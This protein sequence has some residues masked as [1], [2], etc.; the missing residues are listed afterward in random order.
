MKLKFSIAQKLIVGFGV[1]LFAVLLTSFM[2]YQNLD[3]NLVI[4]RR[5]VKNH[6][7]S[8]AYLTDLHSLITNSK[9]LIK[10][11]VFISN[12][13]G[14]DDKIELQEIHSIGYPNLIE[15]LEPLSENWDN[16][17]LLLYSQISSNIDTLFRDYKQI[18]GM[19]Q[20]FDDYDN[21]NITILAESYV[22]EYGR[23]TELADVI[24]K[25]IEALRQKQS[26]TVDAANVEMENSFA[27][28]QQLIVV[29]GVILLFAII[30]IA[31]ILS[32]AMVVPINRIKKII[33]QMGTGILPKVKH[34]DRTDEIGEM[35]E[36]LQV[37]IEGL[38]KTS[39]FAIK[40]GE[41]NYKSS[42]QPLGKKDELGNS[43][44]L[45]RQNL[46]TASEDAENR[47][48]E[49]AQ[50]SWS[51][52]GIAEFGE[53]MRD[54]NDNL[55][56]FSAKVLFKLVRYLKVNLGGM[57]IINDENPDDVFLELTAFYAYDRRKFESK[58]I[59][60]GENL[61]G[62]CVQEKETTYLNDIP[63]DY[64]RIVSGLGKDLPKSLV[65]VPL[66]LNNIVYG[67]VELASFISL[68]KYQIEFIEKIGESIASSISSV[69]IKNHT[70]KLL[71]ESNEKSEILVRQE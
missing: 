34:R 49:N 61:V 31:F 37:L 59:E 44:L 10:S 38:R 2:T 40:I 22:D 41:G 53:L 67:A 19:L 21:M 39:E 17:D 46:S 42:Y 52:Q 14:T 62:Q 30:L 4:N 15:K 56:E 12:K 55:E 64:V 20:S 45:M 8:E 26:E 65:V 1:L 70:A 60:I 28:F 29:M 35:E 66:K 9:M 23:D 25:D 48:L 43:L 36:A 3:K 32:R 58:R 16:R 27:S 13:P 57:F 63:E 54:S 6:I 47:R 11:W 50:R 69:K 5:I 24:L 18:M 51:A 71:D 68:E 7:P 33:R